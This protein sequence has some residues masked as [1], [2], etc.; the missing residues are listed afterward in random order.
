MEDLKSTDEL[1]EMIGKVLTEADNDFILE[2]ASQV[3][4]QNIKYI[5]DN[6]FILTD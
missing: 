1:I 5:G 2:I 6:Q 4:T 3:L